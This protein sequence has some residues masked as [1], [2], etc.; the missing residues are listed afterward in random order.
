MKE[1]LKELSQQ[2]RPIIKLAHKITW[3]MSQGRD[4]LWLID[5]S[6]QEK[7]WL[8]ANDFEYSY[9]R[10]IYEYKIIL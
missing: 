3:S 1:S 2:P 5:L 10:R 4:E 8:K 6:R 7:D 9:S